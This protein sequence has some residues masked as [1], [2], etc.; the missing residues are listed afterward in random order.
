MNPAASDL[1]QRMRRLIEDHQAEVCRALGL[2]DGKPF[3]RDV[4]QRQEGGGGLTAVLTEGNVFERAGVNTS[5]VW[6]ELDDVAWAKMASRPNSDAGAGTSARS[7]REFFATGISMVLHPRSPMVPTMHA[8]FRYLT[9]GA[10]AW[11]GGGSDLTPYYP[12]LEDVVGFH[13]GWKAICDRHDAAYYP[14]FKAWCDE[15][16]YIRH[17]REMRGVGGIFFDDLAGD[18]ERSFAFVTDCCRH[19]LE[20]YLPIV[21]RLRDEEY[22][23]RERRFQLFRR[24]RYVEFNLVYD[25]G[26]AFG[27]A[28]GGRT[29]SILMS[30][31]PL[32]SWSYAYQPERGSREAEAMRFFQPQDWLGQSGATVS[33]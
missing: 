30:L 31:P 7:G 23:E 22:G 11:F 25:R 17:R 1:G 2:V 8:N 4:W 12:Q 33:E 26:T 29:E 16:F 14:R 9:R 13:S 27:L 28:T 19:V 10:E 3:Q 15:Y 18:L 20:P 21:E 6:G 5:T 24:G 32:A